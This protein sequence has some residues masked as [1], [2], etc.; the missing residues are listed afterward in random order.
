MVDVLG[1]VSQPSHFGLSQRVETDIHLHRYVLDVAFSQCQRVG[2]VNC[3]DHVGTAFVIP[4][5]D[6][7][8]S[9]I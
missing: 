7:H 2:L 5:R 1:S 4:R 8:L 6:E 9:V 3:T